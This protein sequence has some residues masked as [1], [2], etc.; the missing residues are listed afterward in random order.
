[1]VTKK[2]RCVGMNCMKCGSKRAENQAFCEE[3]LQH[4]SR[5][6]VRPNVVVQLPP[7]QNVVAAKKKR[8]AKKERKPDEQLRHLRKIIRWLCLLLVVALLAF[9]FVAFLLLRIADQQDLTA[10]KLFACSNPAQIDVSRET[11]F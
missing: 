9:G 8:M 4:M 11:F 2:R 10:S 3:C 6:P 7:R 5:F 1:M